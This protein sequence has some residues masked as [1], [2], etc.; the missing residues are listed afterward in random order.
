MV[1]PFLARLSSLCAS[2][3]AAIV[4]CSPANSVWMLFMQAGSYALS[5]ELSVYT[6]NF[7]LLLEPCEENRAIGVA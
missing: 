4:D 6:N 7:L 1:G 3:I 2:R 5:P